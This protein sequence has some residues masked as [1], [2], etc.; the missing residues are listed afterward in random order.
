VICRDAEAHAELGMKSV[1]F[2]EKESPFPS[3]IARACVEAATDLDL[4]VIVAFTETGTT[5][6]LI[7]KYRP[8]AGIVAFTALPGTYNRMALYW[9]VTPL[10]F[11]R[12]DSTDE[13]IQAAESRLVEMG[14][15]QPGERVA[16]V[17]GVPPNQR[18]ATNLL[19]LHKVG[20]VAR[21]VPGRA[22]R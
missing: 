17:A 22:G 15:V 20:E 18:S 19:K 5:A 21:G 3:A 16:M 12:L 4:P 14:L 13:M 11:E 9:G 10:R 6:R 7:S 1:A 2:L 8:A